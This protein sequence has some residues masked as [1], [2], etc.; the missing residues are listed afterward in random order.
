MWDSSSS[1]GFRLFKWGP[2]P[3]SFL[4]PCWP[5]W[6]TLEIWDVVAKLNY[7]VQPKSGVKSGAGR[8]KK[9]TKKKP[10]SYPI[11]NYLQAGC[12][13]ILFYLSVPHSVKWKQQQHLPYGVDME[14]S[15]VSGGEEVLFKGS[16]HIGRAAQSFALSVRCSS[17]F[18]LFP[19]PCQ[20]Y[21]GNC[22]LHTPYL[23]TWGCAWAPQY[24]L[25]QLANFYILWD[26][27]PPESGDFLNFIFPSLHCTW[28]VLNKAY[29]INFEIMCFLLLSGALIVL[30]K[31]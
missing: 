4:T 31:S 22:L 14:I 23:C 16:G 12:E 18:G 5:I 7:S 9:E 13:S 25:H 17:S 1:L 11:E 10:K 30:F 26:H 2:G 24:P 20:S 15:W 28:Q 19:N 29:L 27:E 6:D 3:S 8:E 21:C